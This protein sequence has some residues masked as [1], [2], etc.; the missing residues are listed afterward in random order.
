MFYSPKQIA[1]FRQEF[2]RVTTDLQALM[3][4]GMA[5][6]QGAQCDDVRKYLNHGVGRRLS[7]LKRSTEQIFEIFPPDREQKLTRDEVTFVQVF[8][9]AFVINLSGVFDNWAWAF[10]HRHDLL[11]EVGGALNVGIFKRNT[12]RFLADTLRDYLNE[13]PISDWHEK[14]AKNYRD[15]LAHR[16]PLYVPPANWT[17]ED[18]TNYDR[19]EVEKAR[20]I[21][22]EDW[23]QLDITW[24]E[25]DQIGTPCFF[26]MHEYSPDENARPVYLHPQVLIDGMTVVEFGNKFYESWDRRGN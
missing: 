15:A 7:I 20:L 8:L 23:D 9:H 24:N 25:Q 18:R 3:F 16:I 22:A 6:A 12:Q 26:F 1:Q 4:R 11:A 10:I 19:L 13:S 21:G 17:T 2:G 5:E 14:Y